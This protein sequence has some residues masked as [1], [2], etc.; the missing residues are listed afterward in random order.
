LGTVAESP[1]R[2]SIETC[3]D[4]SVMNREPHRLNFRELGF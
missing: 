4:E 3:C 1:R 2:S